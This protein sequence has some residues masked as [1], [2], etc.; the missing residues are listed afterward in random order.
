MRL[1]LSI[2]ILLAININKAHTA[3]AIII[4]LIPIQNRHK[5]VPNLQHATVQ[6]QKPIIMPN[7]LIIDSINN[8]SLDLFGLAIE[9]QFFGDFVETELDLG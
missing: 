5:I 7:L 1:K 8:N 9:G 2:D 6:I 3:I 4:I